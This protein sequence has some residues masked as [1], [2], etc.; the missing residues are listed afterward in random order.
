[1]TLLAAAMPDTSIRVEQ[2]PAHKS[3]NIEDV[4]LSASLEAL[5]NKTGEFSFGVLGP[6]YRADC[7]CEFMK[8]KS[9]TA[10]EAARPSYSSFKIA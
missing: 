5:E 4:L 10:S 8:D 6:S 3:P 1:M 2:R 7:F 9:T